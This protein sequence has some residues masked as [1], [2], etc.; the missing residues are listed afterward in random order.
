M[1]LPDVNY[2]IS[3]V[4]MEGRESLSANLPEL[5]NVNIVVKSLTQ[6]V[7]IP[8]KGFV[9]SHVFVRQKTLKNQVLIS[10]VIIVIFVKNGFQKKMQY[11]KH[12]S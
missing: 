12:T 6:E 1:I 5:K 10:I 2:I 3:Y 7:S 9:Q 11:G 4:L 8:N